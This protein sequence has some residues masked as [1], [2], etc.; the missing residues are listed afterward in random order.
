MRRTRSPNRP[1]VSRGATRLIHL[2]IE[3]S[4]ASSLMEDRYWEREIVPEIDGLL[5]SGNEKTITTALESLWTRDPV[6]HDLVADL[7]E[8][9]AESTTADFKGVPHDFILVAVPVLAWS[10]DKIPCGKLPAAA[11]KAISAQL[12]GHV[13]AKAAHVTLAPAIFSPD[14][15]PHQ[16]TDSYELARAMFEAMQ[17]GK[18]FPIDFSSWP[19]TGQFV[20]DTRLIIAGVAVPAG[21]AIFRWQE[22]EIS[23]EKVLATWREQGGAVMQAAMPGCTI[24]PLLPSAFHDGSRVADREGRGFSLKAGVQF[25]EAIA[26]ITPR[27]MVAVIAPFYERELEEYRISLMREG[28]EDVLHGVV[29][30]VLGTEAEEGTVADEIEALLK[31]MGVVNVVQIDHKFPLEHCSDCG[32]PMFSD[33]EAELVHAGFPEDD[34]PETVRYH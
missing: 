33:T 5:S 12:S 34:V 26:N 17:T 28:R 1:A 6:A 21:G 7:I 23:R 11:A 4:E 30:P 24:E 9:R 3:W 10:R 22:E 2:A 27:E 18:T 13:L 20:A 14:Q 16:Y 31:L 29:W 32:A 25:L 15:L 19:E 8:S